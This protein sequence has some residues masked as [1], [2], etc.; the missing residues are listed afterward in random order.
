MGSYV[1]RMGSCM[2]ATRRQTALSASI[3]WCFLFEGMGVVRVF[4]F[5]FPPAPFV[6]SSSCCSTAA[7]EC[8]GGFGELEFG[9]WGFG[10]WKKGDRAKGS[11]CMHA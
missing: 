4:P 6:G 11:R 9:V 8:M 1:H 7:V 2:Q 3:A 10:G 5:L